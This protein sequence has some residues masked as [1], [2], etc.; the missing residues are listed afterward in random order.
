MHNSW[1]DT[2]APLKDTINHL[3]DFLADQATNGPGF[4]PHHTNIWRAYTTDKNTIK[5]LILGQDPYPTPGHGIGLAFATTKDTQPLPKSLKNI[6][7]E[8]VNDQH[9]PMPQH[10][11]LTA[12]THQGVALINTV[13]TVAPKTPNSHKN[14]GWETITQ[15]ALSALDNRGTPLV[16]ILWGAH[17]QKLRKYLPNTHTI[18]SPHPSPLSA[19]RGFFGSQPFSATNQAL[20]HQG[21]QPINW[22][23]PPTH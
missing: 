9:I 2:F 1:K 5:V 10:G 7:T 8:L 20:I 4:L 16:A 22:T 15:H 13:L 18:T 23:I 3:N 17:A 12:W 6:Y 14:Q 11:D 21:A 19:H